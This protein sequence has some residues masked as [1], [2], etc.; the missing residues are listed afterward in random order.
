MVKKL[1][2]KTVIEGE[3]MDAL[4]LQQKLDDTEHE[5]MLDPRFKQYLALRDQVNKTWEQVRKNVADVMIP[6]YQAG[7]IDKTLKGSWGTITVTE[8]DQFEIDEAE[9][10][11]GYK[12]LVPDTTKIRDHYHFT[13]KTVKGAKQFK[14]Y[15]IMLKFKKED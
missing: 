2:E 3:V 9:L 7:K 6:A 10:P 15:G 1:D 14:K 13:G 5:L 12:K 4:T 11:R 8:S